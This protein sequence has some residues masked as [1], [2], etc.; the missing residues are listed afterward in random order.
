MNAPG[1]DEAEQKEVVVLLCSVLDAIVPQLPS[2]L[3][4]PP[5]RGR[6]FE[7]EEP[8]PLCPSAFVQVRSRACGRTRTPRSPHPITWRRAGMLCRPA[9]RR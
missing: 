4:P 9:S 2:A 8:C 3:C 6:M 7:A 1:V 5:K